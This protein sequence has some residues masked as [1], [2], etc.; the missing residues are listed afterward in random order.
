MLDRSKSPGQ[1]YRD[2]R[3][4][5]SEPRKGRPLYASRGKPSYA[6]RY[7]ANMAHYQEQ[8]RSVAASP[9]ARLIHA[10]RTLSVNIGNQTSGHKAFT[11]GRSLWTVES[12]PREAGS[13]R[14]P[15]RLALS[16]TGDFAADV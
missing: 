5:G 11:T 2:L 8:F 1:V 15:W 16:G 6:E 9:G 14:G 12:F 13:M 7:T 4:G 10:Y 3:A